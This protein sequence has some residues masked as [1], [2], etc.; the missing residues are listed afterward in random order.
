MLAAA[1][2]WLAILPSV[3]KIPTVRAH[4]DR[5]QAG[6]VVTTA[7]FY[8]ELNWEPPTGPVWR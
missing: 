3:A 8:T 1:V 5:M 7:K 2:F 4:I 6:N